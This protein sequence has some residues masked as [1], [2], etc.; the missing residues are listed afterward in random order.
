[1]P[2]KKKV[3]PGSIQLNK[4]IAELPNNKNTSTSSI[5]HDL[6]ESQKEC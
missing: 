5:R 4:L 6:S 2:Y 3:S 1:M